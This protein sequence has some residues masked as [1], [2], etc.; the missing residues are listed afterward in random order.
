[1]KKR[2]II[3]DS[4]IGAL[5][6]GLL[7]L[8]FWEP[9]VKG[10]NELKYKRRFHEEISFCKSVDNDGVAFD[11]VRENDESI[12]QFI[13]EVQEN[14]SWEDVGIVLEKAKDYCRNK[15]GDG[16]IWQIIL[17]EEISSD[18]PVGMKPIIILTNQLPIS[19]MISKEKTCMHICRLDEKSNR[20][21]SHLDNSCFAFVNELILCGS[22][23]TL[24]PL[25]KWTNLS[26]CA[27]EKGEYCTYMISPQFPMVSEEK[28][29]IMC[30]EV[31]GDI[32]FVHYSEQEI[33]KPHLG[34]TYL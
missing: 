3:I 18:H 11:S 19:G 1:M 8:I 27:Y 10:V 20:I 26:T 34:T 5:L 17:S 33:D 30:K 31:Y 28:W 29:S 21:L 9:I 15:Q 6:I 14:T 24:K 13:F 4:L 22:F 7:L 23:E 25:E 32:C 2:R 12:K 16:Q